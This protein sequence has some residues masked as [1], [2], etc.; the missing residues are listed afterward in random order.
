MGRAS[1]ATRPGD[2]R[3]LIHG[4]GL[5]ERTR[6][7]GVVKCSPAPPFVPS[8]SARPQLRKH[9]PRLTGGVPVAPSKDYIRVF[10][11]HKAEHRRSRGASVALIQDGHV[12]TWPGCL[13]DSIQ[14]AFRSV[15][16]RR[17]E[18]R[19]GIA[20][21]V[22]CPRA[23]SDT[24]PTRHA[25][26]RCNG[27]HNVTCLACQPPRHHCAVGVSR[28]VDAPMVES[29]LVTPAGEV[30]QHSAEVCN[31]INIEIASH[32]A[33]RP[34]IEGPRTARPRGSW[35]RNTFGK[36]EAEAVSIRSSKQVGLV[37][38][39]RRISTAAVK[40]NHERRCH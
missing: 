37:C 34:C 25:A 13:Q 24:K 35:L 18:A 40:N 11:S 22:A 12:T 20:G 5:E 17:V 8:P 36:H 27:C 32:T 31:I 6:H 10:L 16:A 21:L 39:S 7:I 28:D 2:A 1:G 9:G 26:I 23:I 3:R 4:P 30:I 29:P 14:R 38:D 15:P 33:A 19:R